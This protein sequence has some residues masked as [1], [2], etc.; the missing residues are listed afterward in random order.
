[1]DILQLKKSYYL[2]A[3]KILWVLTKTNILRK[4]LY[5]IISLLLITFSSCKKNQSEKDIVQ[6]SFLDLDELRGRGKIVAVT[7]FNS[8]NYFVYKGRPMGFHYEMLKS[9]SDFA[10][11]NLEIITENDI[12][13]SIAMLN[14]GEADILAVDL[15]ETPERK[16]LIQFTDPV[17][18][19][20]Q[21]LV[22]RKPNRWSTMTPHEIDKHLLK[23][24]T[25]LKGKTIYVQSGSSAVNCLKEMNDLTGNNMLVVEVPY[26]MEE[27][28]KLVARR[29][30]DY[31]VCDENIAQVNSRYYPILDVGTPV[32]DISDLSWSV[33]KLNSEKLATALNTWISTFR[34]TDDYA[35]LYAKYFK[36]S[37]STYRVKN[38]YYT[39]NTGKVSPWDAFIKS[40]SDTINWDWRLLASLIYQESRFKPDVTSWAGAYGLMQVMPATGKS[41]GIDIKSS[42]ENNIKAG[43]KNIKYLQDFFNSRIPDESERLKFILAAYNA[44]LGNVMDAMALA[45]KHGKDPHI[46]DDNVAYYLL[47]K[48]DPQ[49][50]KDPVVQFGYCRGYEPVNFVSEILQRYSEYKYIIPSD[51]D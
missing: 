14:S 11:V 22:Q 34:N 10:G 37:W 23:S 41:L 38:E 29:N 28:M 49:Y 2:C 26:E 24:K 15:S 20:R 45:Q 35:L 50:Y 19:T 42:P 7:D 33:R 36:N 40:F 27:L 18:R 6:S 12:N 32:S 21:V 39:L 5:F 25:D 17:S 8:T 3:L 9:F 1:M 43:V 16:D 4:G 31:V 30:I 44:G 46:W 51:Q 13:K 47:K 48:T